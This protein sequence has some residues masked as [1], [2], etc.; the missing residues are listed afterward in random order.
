[1]DREQRAAARR[2]R[3]VVHRATDFADAERWDLQFWQSQTPEARL[4]AFAA[5]RADV[6]KVELA[7]QESRGAE[8]Q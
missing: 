3:M 7:R 8:Q 6:A 5:I 1:M 2:K 4:E